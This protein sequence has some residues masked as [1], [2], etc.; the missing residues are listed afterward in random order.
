MKKIVALVCSILLALVVM[1]L[2]CPVTAMDDNSINIGGLGM[3]GP[4]LSAS[5][6]LLEYEHHMG[7]GMSVFGR[8]GAFD[9]S[10]DDGWYREDGDGPGVDVGIRKYLGTNEMRGFYIG[11][12]VGIW[13]TSWTFTDRNYSTFSKYYSGKGETTSFKIDF[14]VGGRLPLGSSPV[15]IIPSFHIG[16]FANIGS[17]SC[18]STSVPGASCDNESDVGFYGVVGLS[19]GIAF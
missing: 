8:V 5:V 17:G 3:V 11:G 10:Y 16:H 1:A 15:S 7:S 19:M 9:Y 14:E 18:T 13:T 6:F 12:T 2:P 4:D